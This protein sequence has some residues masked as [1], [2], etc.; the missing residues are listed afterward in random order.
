MDRDPSRQLVP[1]ADAAPAAP[2]TAPASG[3]RVRDLQFVS[4][5]LGW[6]VAGRGPDG[7]VVTMLRGGRLHHGNL[8]RSLKAAL[9]RDWTMSDRKTD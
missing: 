9:A 3:L 2:A 6:P 4:D 5:L 1:A 8:S 7:P